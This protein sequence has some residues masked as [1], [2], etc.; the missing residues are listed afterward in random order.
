M[1][2]FSN[3]AKGKFYFFC[4]KDR[5]TFYQQL[6]KTSHHE[7]IYFNSINVLIKE[8]IS[9]PPSALLID[10]PSGI[11]VGLEHMTFFNNMPVIW[12][13]VRCNITTNGFAFATCDSP[14]RRDPLQSAMNAIA[15]G[16]ESWTNRSFNRK[17]LRLDM[18]C[19]IR[20]KKDDQNIWRR[21]NTLNI[22]AGGFFA[23]TYDPPEKGSIV[24]IELKD[25]DNVPIICQGR[26]MWSRTW[27]ESNKLPGVGIA[28]LDG[29]VNTDF[30]KA[31]RQPKVIRQ[32]IQDNMF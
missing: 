12:P 20:I 32:F 3:R 26:T 10:I 15:R 11:K 16:D 5:K 6:L 1:S 23:V 25:L 19:R 21:G 13:I 9:T 17:F 2:I 29:A 31:L 14:A 7:V 4:E 22:S 24:E 28:L 30:I 27:D 18:G 8:I